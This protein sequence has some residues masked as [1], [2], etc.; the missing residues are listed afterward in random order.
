MGTNKISLFPDTFKNKKKILDKVN[1]IW[2]SYI[3]GGLTLDET[4]QEIINVTPAGFT[5]PELGKTH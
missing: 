5:E 3:D 1:N 2:E 4:R